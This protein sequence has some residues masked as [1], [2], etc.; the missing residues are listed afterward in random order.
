MKI[1]NE[2]FKNL[3]YIDDTIRKYAEK[4]Y[5]DANCTYG[6]G[7]YMIHINMVVDAVHEFR[8]VFINTIDIDLTVSAAFLHDAEED[9]R[10]TYNDIMAVAGKKVADI[11]LAVTD[12]PA[13]N[14]LLRHLLTMPKTVKDYRAIILKMCDMYANASYSKEHG[15]SMYE[16]YVEEYAYR[17]PIFKKA[18]TWYKCELNEIELDRFWIALDEVHNINLK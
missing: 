5:A 16:K 4:C 13:E 8:M 15:S 3:N 17:K 9:A 10:K 14:R 18:L 12:V 7:S 6:G 2:K 1:M 11:V